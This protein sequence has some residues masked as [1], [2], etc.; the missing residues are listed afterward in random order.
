MR[1]GI[2]LV[3]PNSTYTNPNALERERGDGM[4][5]EM[6]AGVME[7]QSEVDFFGST[8]G[9]A[10]PHRSSTAIHPALPPCTF[11]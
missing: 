1:N 2:N 9:I 11:L 8:L 4:R 3:F 5:W 6:G 10:K 7:E